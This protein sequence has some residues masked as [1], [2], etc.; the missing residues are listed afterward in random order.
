[1]EL[2]P[3][4]FVEITID[5]SHQFMGKYAP[6]RISTLC[7]SAHFIRLIESLKRNMWAKYTEVYVGLDYP[8]NEKYLKGW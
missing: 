1:M 8:P 5:I 4:P 6:V 3:T 2:Y 7:R